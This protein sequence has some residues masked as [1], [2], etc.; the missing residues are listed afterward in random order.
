MRHIIFITPV[1]KN[2]VKLFSGVNEFNGV[3]LDGFALSNIGRFKAPKYTDGD[4]VDIL[5]RDQAFML[6]KPSSDNNFKIKYVNFMGE[7]TRLTLIKEAKPINSAMVKNKIN[8]IVGLNIDER[9]V[10]LF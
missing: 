7:T 6:T 10:Y 2:T 5:I 4:K 1:D 3:I 9:F 8:D